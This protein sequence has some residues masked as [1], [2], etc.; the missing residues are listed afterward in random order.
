[1]K[2]FT[3]FVLPAIVVLI[4]LVIMYFLIQAIYGDGQKK[5]GWEQDIIG[6]WI[7][8]DGTEKLVI[9]KRSLIYTDEPLGI[10]K[11]CDY[12]TNYHETD[13]EE[14]NFFYVT[15]NPPND[16][17]TG[18][19]GM[20]EKIEYRGRSMFGGIMISD[21]GYHETEFRKEW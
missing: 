17:E 15:L 14:N 13:N 5:P 3:T 9:S 1:M 19:I 16:N 10:E 20:F 4:L 11:T 18:M 2:I 8:E 21:V 7:T 12:V 6:T